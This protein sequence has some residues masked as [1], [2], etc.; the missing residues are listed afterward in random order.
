M[1]RLLVAGSRT[2]HT[3]PLG[4][5][6][7]MLNQASYAL[8]RTFDVVIH[9]GAK[10]VDQIA[11]LWASHKGYPVTVYPAR[12]DIYGR[13]AGY[14]RNKIMVDLAEAAL[15]VWDGKSK[16]TK[17]TMDLAVAAGLPLVIVVRN[18]EEVSDRPFKGYETPGQTT[19]ETGVGH[20]TPDHRVRGTKEAL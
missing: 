17:H 3:W 7:D 9:G 10:G 19:L 20:Q 1:R 6:E 4:Q 16:G 5:V 18:P 11:G 14:I 12:W 13:R 15:V 8:D 2:F